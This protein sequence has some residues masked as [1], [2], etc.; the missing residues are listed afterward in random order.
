MESSGRR[1]RCFYLVR[2]TP[3]VT[4]TDILRGPRGT[5]FCG[6]NTSWS[7]VTSLT[8]DHDRQ[9]HLRLNQPGIS[10]I[11]LL[12]WNFPFAVICPP[13]S[14]LIYIG[15][16]WKDSQIS[17]ITCKYVSCTLPL[18]AHYRVMRVLKEYLNRPHLFCG[19]WNPSLYKGSNYRQRLL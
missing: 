2:V 15:V 13:M 6:A 3:T 4:K 10:G 5:R 11:A 7:L 1:R 16:Q 18:F 19:R 8:S 9:L 14:W 12:F 17:S